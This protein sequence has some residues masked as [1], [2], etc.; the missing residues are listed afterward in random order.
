MALLFFWTTAVSPIEWQKFELDSEVRSTAK[1]GTVQYY[2][3]NLLFSFVSKVLENNTSNIYT[4]G[5]FNLNH[6]TLN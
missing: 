4:K 6:N 1:V 3:Y 2:S 5:N